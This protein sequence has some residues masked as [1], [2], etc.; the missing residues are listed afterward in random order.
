M[1]AWLSSRLGLTALDRREDLDDRT[2]VLVLFARFTD[3]V[4]SGLMI[5]L[6]PTLRARLGLS[7]VQAGWCFQAL[8]T[9]AA[10]VEPVAGAALDLMRRRPLIVWGAAGWGA[11]LLLAAGAPSFGWLVAAFAVAG[12]AS[13]PLAHTAD[14]V[15]IE[16]HPGAVERIQGRSTQIDTIG[17]LLAPG[18]VAAAGWLG[19]D[20][21]A[22]LV[23]AGG[24]AL[25]Y[26]AL[27]AGSIVPGP[28]TSA[29]AAL[30]PVARVVANVR[31][32]LTDP[33]GRYWL[34]AL[35]LHELL[36]L[37][38]LFEPIWLR[39]VVG[40]SQ[41]LVAVH[42]AVGLVG[43]L[44]G[45]L[46]A[47][48][49][50]GRRD[51]EPLLRVSLV[52]TVI[53]YP[54]WLLTP[55]VAARFLLVLPRNLVMAPLWPVL[56]SRALAATPGTAGTVSAISSLTGVVPLAPLFSWAAERWGLTA[57]MLVVTLGTLVVLLAVLRPRAVPVN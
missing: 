26:A 43:T 39:D 35:L 10:V 40:A 5:V 22:V 46:L 54:L 20:Q 55:G 28:P 32:V 15:L 2:T 44:I 56:R 7:V 6:M 33:A 19:V 27:L 16:G 3:E 25:V 24:G 13:G 18:A 51:A 36:D 29:H 14:V 8:F 30:A 31:T 53:L 17:A 34:I 12:A 11:S 50:L 21:R 52:G 49:W 1:F 47:D 23:V 9:V 4:T 38:E 37:P 48:R 57:T 41:S 42:V 45:L